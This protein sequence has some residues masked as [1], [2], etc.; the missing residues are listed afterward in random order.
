MRSYILAANKNI[1]VTMHRSDSIFRGVK[2]H[3]S[4]VKSNFLHG[5]HQIITL[6]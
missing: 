2:M 3:A 6:F 1:S 4:K 5:E